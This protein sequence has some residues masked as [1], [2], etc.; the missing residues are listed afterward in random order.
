MSIPVKYRERD[1]VYGEPVKPPKGDILI[2]DDTM[3]SLRALLAMLIDNGYEVRGAQNGTTA[4]MVAKAEPPELILLDVMMP[5]MDGYEVCRRLKANPETAAIPII[6]ISALEEAPDKIKGFAAGGV[7]F[8]SKPFQVAEVLARVETH[9]KLSALQRQLTAKNSRLKEEIEE[10]QRAEAALRCMNGELEHRVEER[11]A[12]LAS[13]NAR[14]REYSEN[15]EQLVTSRTRKLSVLYQVTAVAAES[16]GLEPTLAKS[17]EQVLTVMESEQGAIHLVTDCGKRL[18]LAVQRGLPKAVAGRAR[19]IAVDSRLG[20][21]LLERPDPY[22]LANEV[23]QPFLR[24]LRVECEPQAYVGLP[25]RAHGVVVGILSFWREQGCAPLNDD[26]IALLTSLGEQM[27]M[28][29]ESAR[30]RKQAQKTAV[31]EERSRLARDLH[32][33]VTQLLYSATLIAAAGR[34]SH[35]NGNSAQAGKC[36]VELGEIAQQALKEMRLLIFELRPPSLKREGLVGT[37]QERLDTVEGR[38]NVNTQLLVDDLPQLTEKAQ[39]ALYYVAQEALNNALK[40]AS[41]STLEVML[42]TTANH[43]VLTIADDGTGFNPDTLKGCGGLGLV[44]MRE[45][46]ALFGGEL[47]VDSSPH[48]GTRIRARLPIA[49]ITASGTQTREPA[50]EA[51]HS[52]ND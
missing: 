12:A 29:V 33:S 39:D 13:A 43:V 35:H 4:L 49:T 17:L 15:L 23:I 36:L 40:H 6:F 16:L 46:A 19:S 8:I 18:E 10:R 22:L 26:N 48:E 1:Q 45:R 5:A 27:G 9:L 11:T 31:M 25:L 2:V 14:I 52:Q 28:V 50:P 38:A 41:A 51:V 20:K 42:E 37:L 47:S 3:E 24:E 21:A 32:D 34:E 30:L 44:S 7:D